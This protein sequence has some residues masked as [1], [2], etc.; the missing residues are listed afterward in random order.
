MY[1]CKQRRALLCSWANEELWTMAW[2]LHC[3]HLWLVWFLVT[4]WKN[5]QRNI[6]SV[7]THSYAENTMYWSVCFLSNAHGGKKENHHSSQLEDIVIIKQ[8]KSGYISFR[9][10]F[11]LNLNK[12]SLRSQY[13]DSHCRKF[14]L[15]FFKDKEIYLFLA[16]LWIIGI[17]NWGSFV[18]FLYC[19]CLHE[20]FKGTWTSE[21][22]L[23]V[24]RTLKAKGENCGTSL[25]KATFIFK[26]N[27]IL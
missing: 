24:P 8:G 17:K 19:H 3:S 6:S 14:V 12:L 7:H 15:M 4:K 1:L 9:Y 23:S 11:H 16:F 13:L 5:F 18:K 22:H 26:Y 25:R 27:F 2:L 20:S 21:E 10:N